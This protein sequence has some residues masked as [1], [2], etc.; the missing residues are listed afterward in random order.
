[1]TQQSSEPDPLNQSAES[2][3]ALR[4]LRQWVALGA[5]I[6][7]LLLLLLAFVLVNRSVQ[8]D[9]ARGEATATA[10]GQEQ[11]ELQNPGPTVEAMRATLT[12]TR[13][14]ADQILTAAPP[15]GILWPQVISVL[16]RYDPNRLA[17]TSLTQVENRITVTGLAADDEVVVAYAQA[18]EE[19]KRFVTVVLQ[20]LLIVPAPTAPPPPTAAVTPVPPSAVVPAIQP[21]FLTSANT[22]ANFVII[23]EVDQ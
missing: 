23:V 18:L 4:A 1:M 17:L 5:V 10:L 13:A 12:T 21:P 19:S 8:N 16:D 7:A 11:Q 22:L 3:Q 2:L 9:L 15:V 20:S 6:L 14:L